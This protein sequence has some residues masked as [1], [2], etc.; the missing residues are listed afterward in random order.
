MQNG[1]IQKVVA[2]SS[3][4]TSASRHIK[5]VSLYHQQI[6]ELSQTHPRLQHRLQIHGSKRCTKS[7]NL[8]PITKLKPKKLRSIVVSPRR[9]HCHLFKK[10]KLNWNSKLTS[11][12][13]IHGKGRVMHLKQPKNRPISIFW[14]KCNHVNHTF[15]PSDEKCIPQWDGEMTHWQQETKKS[16]KN[17]EQNQTGFSTRTMF[18]NSME[19]WKQHDKHKQKTFK[20]L[21][22]WRHLSCSAVEQSQ[23][24]VTTFI[25]LKHA[26][27]TSLFPNGE[28]FEHNCCGAWH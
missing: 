17:T 26:A 14:S 5:R 23:I 9:F 24:T 2:M 4:P 21:F 16:T 20:C 1:F 10:W 6:K 19:Q 12:C 27:A 28:L 7:S 11:H 22:V 25:Q 13:L 18:T 3:Q 8:Q 15:S